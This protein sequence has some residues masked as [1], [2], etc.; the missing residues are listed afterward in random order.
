[1]LF[2]PVANVMHGLVVAGHTPC[3]TATRVTHRV[4]GV[5]D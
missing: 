5:V 3:A 1:M 2:K 4:M